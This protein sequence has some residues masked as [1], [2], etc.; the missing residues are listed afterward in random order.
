MNALTARPAPGRSALARR[1]VSAAKRRRLAAPAGASSIGVVLG[2]AV[3]VSLAVILVCLMVSGLLK[4]PEPPEAAAQAA[5]V[6]P[7]DN[8][9]AVRAAMY[10]CCRRYG[11][12]PSLRTLVNKR[13][14]S[15]T[16]LKYPGHK[17]KR[18]SD[19]FYLRPAD[20]D[21]PDT[22]VV[23]EFKDCSDGRGRNY[24][25]VRDVV[26]AVSD[27]QARRASEDEFQALL[28]LPHNTKF[29]AALRRVELP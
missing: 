22:L 29:A 9:E 5:P 14:I 13:L 12:P 7:T 26:G 18:T 10:L 2:S 11:F 8:L 15:E 19:Y 23:C 24:L 1:P 16:T 25:L 21:S 20:N 4:P 17:S 3:T 6:Q 28:L 27:G